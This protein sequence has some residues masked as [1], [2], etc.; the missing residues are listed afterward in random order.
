MLVAQNSLVPVCPVPLTV[1]GIDDVL[2]PAAPPARVVPARPG[3][4][5]HADDEQDEDGVVH[6]ADGTDVDP[7]VEACVEIDH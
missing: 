2:R 1:R 7:V 4:G 6:G 5:V 3:V